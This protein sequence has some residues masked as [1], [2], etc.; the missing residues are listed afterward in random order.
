MGLVQYEVKNKIAYVTMNRP[1]KRNALSPEL[2]TELQQAFEAAA[3][4]TGVKVIVLTGNG[5][6]FCAGADLAYLQQLQ[7][8]TYQENL[9]DSD[10][11]KKLL[12]QIYHHSKPVIA[13]VQGHAIAGGCGLATVCDFVYAAEEAKFGY[14]EVKIGFVPAMVLI[15]LIRKI[16]EARASELLLSGDLITAD[17]ARQIGL[18]HQ[19][20]PLDKLD[21]EVDALADRLAINNSGESMSLTKKLMKQVQNLTL[22]EALDKA[23]E[24]NARARGTKDCQ[25]GIASFLNKQNIEW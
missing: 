5:S 10:H 14:T 19:V 7:G 11:L 18:A 23:S 2:V 6:A 17:M 16:G 15:F 3:I 25:R 4:D 8:F 22:E 1:E 24:T 13:K 12:T 21:Q 20:S 9:D